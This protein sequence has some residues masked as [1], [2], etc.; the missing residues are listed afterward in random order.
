MEFEPHIQNVA[1]LLRYQRE[2]AG[3]SKEELAQ[4]IRISVWKYGRSFDKDHLQGHERENAIRNW[5]MKIGINNIR[6]DLRGRKAKELLPHDAKHFETPIK[7]LEQREGQIDYA[8]TYFMMLQILSHRMGKLTQEQQ[9]IARRLGEGQ[10]A[11]QI[12]REYLAPKAKTK[13]ASYGHEKVRGSRAVNKVLRK[14]LRGPRARW[15]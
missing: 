2:A 14:L 7:K 3:I 6:K 15:K 13:A 9:E 11:L 12:Y 1:R 4:L 5:L 8:R 10:N